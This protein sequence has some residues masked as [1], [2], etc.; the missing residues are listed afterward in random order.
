MYQ[1]LD[2]KS[3]QLLRWYR[4]LYCF[5]KI[6]NKQAPGYL[7][8]MISNYNEAY[9]TRHVAN[10]PYLIFKHNILEWNKLDLCLCLCLFLSLSRCGINIETTSQVF[11]H[12]PL[13]HA[14]WSSLLNNITEINSTILNKSASVVT[15]SRMM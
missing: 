15:L 5:Y 6:Y 3:L 9:E 1:E 14:K 2:L 8:E 10:V 4:K 11:L 7:S 12:C 13:F